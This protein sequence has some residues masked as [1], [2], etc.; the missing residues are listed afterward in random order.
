L[1]ACRNAFPL[2]GASALS[3]R[4]RCTVLATEMLQQPERSRPAPGLSKPLPLWQISRSGFPET[5][6][7][8]F[9]FHRHSPAPRGDREGIFWKND[10]T[11]AAQK[12]RRSSPNWSAPPRPLGGVLAIL[13][14]SISAGKI[15]QH[16]CVN[17]GGRVDDAGPLTLMRQLDRSGCGPSC[18]GSFPFVPFFPASEYSRRPSGLFCFFFFFFFFDEAGRFASSLPPNLLSQIKKIASIA[19]PRPHRAPITRPSQ[20]TYSA[21]S[22]DAEPVIPRILSHHC[23]ASSASSQKTNCSRL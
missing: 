5:I 13:L 15:H 22:A 7:F 1:W 14:Y 4:V 3:Y 19:P 16:P 23:F 9:F 17:A 6:R 10:R 11:R 2:A 18:R 21:V 12:T 20:R 8:V